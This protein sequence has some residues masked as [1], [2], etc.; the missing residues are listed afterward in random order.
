VRW[1]DV[2]CDANGPAVKFRRE[3][4]QAFAKGKRRAK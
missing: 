4:E 2:A 1:A 3:M